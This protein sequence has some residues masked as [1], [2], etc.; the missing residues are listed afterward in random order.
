MTIRPGFE[1]D[2]LTLVETGSLQGQLPNDHPYVTVADELKAMALATYP[3]VPSA[4][5]ESPK[6]RVDRWY[7]FTPTGALD[8]VAGT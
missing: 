4:N 7:D 5:E 3:Y 8:V 6:N 1:K 2:F